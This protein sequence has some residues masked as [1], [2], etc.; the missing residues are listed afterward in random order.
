MQWLDTNPPDH[1][2]ARQI[3]LLTDGEILNVDEV[4]NL[5]RT[6]AT[7]TRIFSFGLGWSPS[8][9]LVKGLARATNG[10]FVFIPPETSVD[11]HVGEQ[12]QKA[13]Q[14]CITNIK[15]RWRLGSVKPISAP[16]KPHPVYANDRLIA[17]ALIEDKTAHFNHHS[18]VKL[19]AGHHRLGV[20][21]VTEQ[22]SLGNNTM[23]ARLA[24]KALILEL[25]HAKLPS[26]EKKSIGSLQ[27]RF[28][29]QKQTETS[30]NQDKAVQKANKKRIIQLSLQ[31]NILSPYTAFVG[32]E[33]RADGNNAEMILREVPIQISA[34][35]RQLQSDLVGF[36]GGA[37]N[38]YCTRISPS[39]AYFRSSFGSQLGAT[40]SSYSSQNHRDHRYLTGTVS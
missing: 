15:V 11:V 40:H 25:Q 36:L 39:T 27:S 4:L 20:A 9:S 37:S 7:T 31:Y 38:N 10:H 3:F 21:R 35:Y 30:I 28:E 16:T 14:P 24:A 12:L 8:R 33:K 22:P 2:R 19:K 5:C 13:L 18:K 26:S 32:I 6:M 34:D 23:I 17:Y 1:G 29:E